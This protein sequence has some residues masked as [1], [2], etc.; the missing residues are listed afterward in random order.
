MLVCYKDYFLV[1][2]YIKLIISTRLH[3]TFKYLIINDF[4]TSLLNMNKMSGIVSFRKNI[5]G[6]LEDRTTAPSLLMR[7]LYGCD[8]QAVLTDSNP[9]RYS[10]FILFSIYKLNTDFHCHSPN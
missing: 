2:S 7:P 5:L 9:L 10:Q 4:D 1:G 8:H 6:W 3:F